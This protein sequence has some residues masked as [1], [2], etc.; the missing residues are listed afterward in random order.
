LVAQELAA[1]GWL[2][3][4]GGSPGAD[5]AFEEGCDLA[6]GRKEIYLPWRGFNGSDSPLYATPAEAMN[7]ALQVHPELR[8]RY[9]RVRK[10]RGRNVCQLLGQ[11]LD[12]PSDFVIAWTEGGVPVGGSATVLQLASARG[13]PV[14]NLGRAEYSGADSETILRRIP[15]QISSSNQ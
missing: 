7:I 2:L 1:R 5:T 9:W 6:G 12:E 15:L 3:R 8:A 11:S 4:S 10:L 13:I 14:I